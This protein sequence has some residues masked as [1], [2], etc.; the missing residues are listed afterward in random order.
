M[1]HDLINRGKAKEFNM[2]SISSVSLQ[3]FEQSGSALIQVGYTITA[4]HHDSAHE[5]AYRELVQ[6]VGVDPGRSELIPGGTVWDGIVVFAPNSAVSF[7]RSRE[8]TLPSSALDEDPDPPVRED[9]IQARV[10]LIPL[11]M[12][13]PS[14]ESN[15]VRRGGPVISPL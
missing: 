15:V 7:V 13:S 4:T 5:Q 14:R 8:I 3:I 1:S 2:A 6:L 10:T 11:P 9:E 12:A